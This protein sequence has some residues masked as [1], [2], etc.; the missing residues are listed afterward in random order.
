MA[1]SNSDETENTK[2]QAQK[3][4]VLIS[5]YEQMR[6]ETR[7]LNQFQSRRF[8]RGMAAIA[9]VIGS[10]FVSKQAL[11][12]VAIIP[13]IIWV[14]FVRQIQSMNWIVRIEGHII[15]IQRE[16]NVDGF[17]YEQKYGFHADDHPFGLTMP[18]IALGL[19]FLAAYIIS[20][21]AGFAVVDTVDV[22]NSIEMISS[23]LFVGG[24][25]FIAGLLALGVLGSHYRLQFAEDRD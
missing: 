17:N 23:P 7:L 2:D 1:D 13:F 10:I 9:V 11:V 15:D 21:F 19:F 14:L 4:D 24:S 12:L 16:L 5:H 3:T 20:S 18:N 25:Y 22:P 8:T 6:Q